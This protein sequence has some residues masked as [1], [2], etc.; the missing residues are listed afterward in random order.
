VAIKIESF[1]DSSVFAYFEFTLI[2]LNLPATDIKIINKN[3]LSTTEPIHL[4][5]MKL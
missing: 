1:Q 2:E 5:I 4:K 3:I